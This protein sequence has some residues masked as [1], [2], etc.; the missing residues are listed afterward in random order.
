MVEKSSTLFP[1]AEFFTSLKRFIAN[2]SL[3]KTATQS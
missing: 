3:I 2:K 1:V